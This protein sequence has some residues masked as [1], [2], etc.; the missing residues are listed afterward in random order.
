[1]KQ[2]EKFRED[3]QNPLALAGGTSIPIIS[4]ITAIV[5]VRNAVDSYREYRRVRELF[6]QEREE[7]TFEKMNDDIEKY[8]FVT[9]KGKWS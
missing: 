8:G 1:M 4:I 2:K 3:S 6:L 9:E 5:S 7:K